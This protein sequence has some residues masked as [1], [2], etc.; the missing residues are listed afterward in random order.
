MEMFRN[1]YEDR[2]VGRARKSCAKMTAAYLAQRLLLLGFVMQCSALPTV[3]EA[4]QF[5]EWV[6][7]GYGLD[8]IY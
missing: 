4:K 7:R 3:G 5:C 2:T 1:F 8:M 6:A